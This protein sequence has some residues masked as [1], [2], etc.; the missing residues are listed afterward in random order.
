MLS[1]LA[2]HFGRLQEPCPGLVTGQSPQR[3]PCRAIANNWKGCRVTFFFR[4]VA[5]VAL[6]PSTPNRLMPCQRVTRRQVQISQNGPTNPSSANMDTT[7]SAGG[8]CHSGSK[9]PEY[10]R[11]PSSRIFCTPTTAPFL[12]PCAASHASTSRSDRNRRMLPQV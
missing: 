5:L 11:C 8:R 6:W 1:R 10:Q 7:S 4:Y 12:W 3:P 9:R 2:Q